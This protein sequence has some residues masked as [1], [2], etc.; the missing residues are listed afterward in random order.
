[1]LYKAEAVPVGED[2]LQHLELTREI[3]RK[4]NHRYGEIFPECKELITPNARVRGL[5]GE[6][7]MSKSLDNYISLTEESEILRKK[8]MV[9]KTDENRKRRTDPGEP[10]I[11]N[12]YSLH[13]LVSS[14]EELDEIAEG[15]RNAS[16]GCV[17]CKKRL[18]ENM[19]K[20][21]APIREKK[22]EL[23]K[24]EDTLKDIL[25]TSVNRLK[26]IAEATMGEVKEAMGLR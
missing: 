14:Q 12:L 17:D 3:V 1:M 19:E 15:C 7:K 25:Q 26:P 8:L 24:D 16:I 9:A 13:K 11:C 10:K 22:E 18:V 2:Q 5:D 21:I 23:L 4:F 6:A 20:L